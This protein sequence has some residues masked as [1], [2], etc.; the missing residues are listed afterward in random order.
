MGTSLLVSEHEYL[1]TSYEPECEFDNGTLIERNTGELPHSI[2]MGQVAFL[3]YAQRNQHRIRVLMILR[4]RIGLGRYRVPD[5]CVCS[6]PFIAVEILSPEDRMSRVRKK[7][8]EYLAFGVPYVWLID[9]ERRR[10][11]VYTPS[12]IYEAKRRGATHRRSPH[13][14]LVG[15]PVPGAR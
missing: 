9:P 11:D 13:R 14:S 4:I 7:I 12:A 2:L 1:T 5:V 3:L 8:D 10:A 15:R 6:P